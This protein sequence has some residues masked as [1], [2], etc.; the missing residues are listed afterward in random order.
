VAAAHR[1]RPGTVPPIGAVVGRWE[2]AAAPVAYAYLLGGFTNF[3][4][5]GRFSRAALAWR[6]FGRARVDAAVSQIREVLAGWGYRLGGQEDKL[7]PTVVCQLL[8]L[9]R[10]PDLE[11]VSSELFQRVRH[12][13]LL[14][15]WHSSVLHA[16]QRAAASLGLCEAPTAGSRRTPATGMTPGWAEWVERWYA[17]S[18]LAPRVRRGFRGAEWTPPRS[19]RASRMARAA[20]TAR[21]GSSSHV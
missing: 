8:L 1:A 5:L 18:T 6:I 16:G 13:H 10:S 2:R 19:R 21:S 15:E 14:P 9:N 20:R 7:L 11:D 17:T 3:V 12:G 4:A